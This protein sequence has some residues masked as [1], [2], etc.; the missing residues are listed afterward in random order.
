MVMRQLLDFG[1]DRYADI[2]VFLIDTPP[3][4][5]HALQQDYADTAVTFAAMETDR[6]RSSTRDKYFSGHVPDASLA[7]LT[8]GEHIPERYENVVYFDGDLFIGA[9]PKALFETTVPEGWICAAPCS[10][11]FLNAEGSPQYDRIADLG[12]SPETYFNAG[13]LALK[14][15]TLQEK[16]P[17]ALDFFSRH[18]DLCK[19][20]DQSALNVVFRDRIVPMSP[21]YNFH[22]Y[23]TET[24]LAKEASP[25]VFHFTGREKPWMGINPPWYGKFVRAYRATARAHPYLDEKLGLTGP[26]TLKGQL[27]YWRRTLLR[28]L[29]APV[30]QERRKLARRLIEEVD[31]YI[32]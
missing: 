20:L 29:P 18:P 6:F 25:V 3:E 28:R 4:T 21:R 10:A 27:R 24:G 17:E 13:V 16:F 12:V 5:L 30:L 26:I 8:L 19:A 11:V 31:H 2:F 22:H 32:G 9:D 23:F 15:T 14:R 7:R 1:V